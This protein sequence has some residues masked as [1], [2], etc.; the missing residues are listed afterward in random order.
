[1][2]L[3]HAPFQPTPA[4][5][6]KQFQSEPKFSN[7]DKWFGDMVQHM[8]K[9]VGEI[10]AHLEQCGLREDTLLLFTGDNGS[11]YGMVKKA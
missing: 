10:V 3:C 4:S 1:M 5:T 8:D 6:D 2:L 7:K 9:V 11:P